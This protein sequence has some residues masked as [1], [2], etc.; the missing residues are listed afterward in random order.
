MATAPQVVDSKLQKM[1]R[2]HLWMHFSRM[3][4]YGPEHEIPL[5]TKADGAYVYDVSAFNNETTGVVTNPGLI[6]KDVAGE[7]RWALQV[8][9]RFEF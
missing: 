7:S 5:I 4:S 3:G 9:F 8:G 6:R 2:D 1:A